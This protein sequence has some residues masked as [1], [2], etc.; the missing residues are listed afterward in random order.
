MADG[1]GAACTAAGE[2]EGVRCSS[3]DLFRAAEKRYRCRSQRSDAHRSARRKRQHLSDTEDF[4][5]VI[6]LHRIDSNGPHLRRRVHL[7][8]RP[9]HS[10]DGL[11]DA[12]RVW[13]ID[14]CPGL[15][16][17]TQALTLPQQLLWAHRCLSGYSNAAHT[18]LTNLRGPQADHWRA[19]CTSGDWSALHQLRWASLGFHY[20][21]TAR[22][23]TPAQHSPFP[24]ALA[25]LTSSLSSAL[26][27]P[28]HP[29][30]ALVNFYPLT[31]S[32]LAHVDD[33]E[34]TRTPPIV[35]VSIGQPA[36]FLMGSRTKASEPTALWLRSGDVMV[37][38]GE[39]RRCYHGVPRVVGGVRWVEEGGVEEEGVEMGNVRAYLESHRININVRQVEDEEHNFASRGQTAWSAGKG[40]GVMCEVT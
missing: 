12:A 11:P 8:P 5:D 10:T 34:L 28:L 36:I 4:S 19:A 17:I 18:N 25:A 32:M 15:S 33:A 2:S 26:H 14:G 40:E 20:D 27:L 24:P 35:S 3:P 16:L 9:P 31:S 29:T 38:G 6:D 13:S 1:G 23:Y 22:S 30:A 39:S 21:W 37:M 7:H